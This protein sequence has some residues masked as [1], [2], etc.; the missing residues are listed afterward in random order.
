VGEKTGG[1]I[2]SSFWN[3]ETT[4]LSESA[5]GTGLATAQMRTADTFVSAGW[6]LKNTWVICEGSDYPRLRW[7]EIDCNEL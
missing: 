4:G 6:D 5:G 1:D 3:I 7:E 2:A